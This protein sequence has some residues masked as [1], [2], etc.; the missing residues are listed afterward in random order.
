MKDL[1][2]D[3]KQVICTILA[4]AGGEFHKKVALYKAFYYAHLFYWQEN[5]GTL[6]DYPI[7]RMPQGPGIDDANR[8]LCELEQEG[9]IEIQ[10]EQYGPFPEYVYLL[11]EKFVIDPTDP[12][13]CAVEKAV[14]WVE[15][16]SAG[17]LSRET[18]EYSRS[19]RQAADGQEL[20]IYL[21][22]MEDEEYL[23]MR[24][25]LQSAEEMVSGIFAEHH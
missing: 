10:R 17:D 21:D 11:K 6:T 18:H 5:A 13:Y 15:G 24:Q 7:V 16:K 9:R 4:A 19:W 8:L 25:R 12:G 3:A 2:E 23:Q 14:K 22:L 20:D 1:S